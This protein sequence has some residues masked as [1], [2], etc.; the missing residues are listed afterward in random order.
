MKKKE[1]ALGTALAG[2]FCLCGCPAPPSPKVEKFEAYPSKVCEYPVT[3]VLEWETTN[4]TYVT[5]T[6]DPPNEML[7]G[8]LGGGTGPIPAGSFE[9]NGNRTEIV[10]DDTVFHLVATQ[11]AGRNNVGSAG[12]DASVMKISGDVD[13]RLGGRGVCKDGVPTWLPVNNRAWTE[14]VLVCMVTSE[15]AIDIEVSH[16][17]DSTTLP[18][19]MDDDGFF[20]NRSGEGVW[21]LTPSTIDPAWVMYCAANP[22]FVSNPPE[23][24]SGDVVISQDVESGPKIDIED[25]GEPPPSFIIHVIGKCGGC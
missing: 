3:V 7:V 16:A 25:I 21:T 13:N 10:E 20:T 1:I 22:E 19:M 11:L 18:S 2:T 24:A 5:I 8:P 14:D 23:S 9:P 15:S 6:K 4:A 12:K 17:G